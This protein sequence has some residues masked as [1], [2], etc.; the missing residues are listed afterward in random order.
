MYN[1]FVGVHNTNME[2]RKKWQGGKQRENGKD[3]I[4]ESMKSMCNEC[5]CSRRGIVVQ[6]SIWFDLKIACSPA[7]IKK[8]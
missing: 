2:Y 5:G 6:T 4:I 8:M 3:Y 7:K 1:R